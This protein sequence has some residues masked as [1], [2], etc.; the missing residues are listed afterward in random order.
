MANGGGGGLLSV[1]AGVCQGCPSS[2]LPC[3]VRDQP[4][5]CCITR[6]GSEANREACRAGVMAANACPRRASASVTYTTVCG[7]WVRVTAM[8][9]GGPRRRP[10]TRTMPEAAGEEPTGAKVGTAEAEVAPAAGSAG[11]P[12]G[13]G[14]LREDGAES[15]AGGAAVLAA[16]RE[17]VGGAEGPRRNQ[18]RSAVV[19]GGEGGLGVGDELLELGWGGKAAAKSCDGG[20]EGVGAADVL[21]GLVGLNGEGGGSG[22]GEGRGQPGGVGMG[23]RGG[24]EGLDGLERGQ[25]GCGGGSGPVPLGH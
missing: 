8:E 4:S 6:V 25:G 24:D 14:R 11:A 18:F 16:C 13:R 21:E 19:R 20:A 1:A 15:G 17:G 22:D 10:K 7:L 3:T 9:A 2:R 5:A 23:L 12:G